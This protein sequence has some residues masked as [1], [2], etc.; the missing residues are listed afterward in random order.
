ML[1]DIAKAFKQLSHDIEGAMANTVTTK[2]QW[3]ME[4]VT[5]LLTLPPI[6]VAGNLPIAASRMLLQGRMGQA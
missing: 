5:H 4:E 2:E 3:P 6:H 1:E